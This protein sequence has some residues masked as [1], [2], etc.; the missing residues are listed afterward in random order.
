MLL[1][2]A[3]VCCRVGSD[4]EMEVRS[5][6]RSLCSL[7]VCLC[8][9]MDISSLEVVTTA[10]AARSVNVD[11]RDHREKEMASVALC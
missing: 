6:C 9:Q 11:H 2:G 5:L 10:L 7:C 8:C 4:I 1:L 3:L